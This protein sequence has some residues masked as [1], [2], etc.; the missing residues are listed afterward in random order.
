LSL[1]SR[2]LTLELGEDATAE[3]MMNSITMENKDYL[4]MVLEGI[5]LDNSSKLK[6]GDEILLI[7]PI[8]GG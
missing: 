1:E 3:D 7:A 6:D 4:Y 2:E 5:R 8:A